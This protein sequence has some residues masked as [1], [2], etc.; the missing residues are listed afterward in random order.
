VARGGDFVDLAQLSSGKNYTSFDPAVVHSLDEAQ[1]TS[2]LFDGLFEFEFSSA[3][4]PVLRP[5]AAESYVVNPQASLYVFKIRPGLK[6]A[7]G[8]PVLPSNFKRAWERAARKSMDS[9]YAYLFSLIQGGTSLIKGATTSLPAVLADDPGLT[10]TVPLASPNVDFPSITTALAFSPLSSADLKRVPTS[11]GWGAKGATI[12]NGPFKL[13]SADPL[14]PVTADRSV[15]L[16]RNQLWAGDFRGRTSANLDSVT[17]QISEDVDNAFERFDEGTG[18][19]AKI[20]L[21]RF[22]DA[23]E[24][25]PNTAQTALLGSYYFDFGADSEAAGSKNLALRQAIS[26]AIDR[27]AI[28]EKVFLGSRSPSSGIT[29]PGIPGTKPNLCEFCEF[30][31]ERARSLFLRWEA[32]GGQLEGPI[33]MQYPSGGNDAEVVSLLIEQVRTVLGIDI[34]PLP[35]DDDY[36]AE[37]GAEDGCGLCRAGWYADYPAYANFMT[38]VFAATSIGGNNVSRT[39]DERLN[40]LFAQAQRTTDRLAR[41]QL[42]RD[43]EGRILNE[44]TLVVPINW[45][46]GDQVHR[47][48]IAN[49]EQSPLGLVPW[50]RVGFAP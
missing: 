32:A 13:R 40:N 14:R 19:S 4:D 2:A 42:F 38:D 49:Y 35:V 33:R 20:P 30:D 50:D 15:V 39:D 31:A 22:G 47:E 44:L 23:I 12:G 1:I 28:N 9:P 17:F 7:N 41:D 16:E 21:D 36:F 43:A 10:L 5:L 37:I 26:L 18:D 3:C 45:Y 27:E 11:A 6:F 25:Y 46:T 34:E 24:R 48:G 29:P 8:E